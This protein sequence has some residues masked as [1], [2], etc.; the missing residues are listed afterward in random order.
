[1]QERGAEAGDGALDHMHA[2]RVPR[3]LGALEGGVI[4][5]GE[6]VEADTEGVRDGAAHLGLGAK[7]RLDVHEVVGAEG[8]AVE[9]GGVRGVGGIR[10]VGGEIGVEEAVH[11]ALS[12]GDGEALA[13]APGH[14]FRVVPRRE[15]EDDAAALEHAERLVEPAPEPPPP[16][17]ERG[18][19]AL[20]LGLVRRVP[21]GEVGIGDAPVDEGVVEVDHDALHRPV[22][23]RVPERVERR[24]LHVRAGRRSR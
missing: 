15:R 17:H 22:H 24:G 3:D 19:G 12:V 9:H 20:A 21:A 1:M 10:A 13:E 7:T 6:R 8:H 18:A 11:P 16:L 4:E 23:P 14:H 5:E 2:R